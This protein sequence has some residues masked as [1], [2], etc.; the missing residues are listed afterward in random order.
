MTFEG[1]FFFLH[2]EMLKFF[3]AKTQF[4]DNVLLSASFI[5]V[6]ESIPAHLCKDISLTVRVVVLVG[7]ITGVF[8]VGPSVAWQALIAWP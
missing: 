5:L 1:L 6:T 8:Q 7:A 3:F 2:F 4:F